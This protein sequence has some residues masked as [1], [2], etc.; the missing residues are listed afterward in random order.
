VQ[1]CVA[2]ALCVVFGR[3]ISG[4]LRGTASHRKVANALD[5]GGK[6]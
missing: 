4:V 5:S 1:C 2:L 6:K 3:I